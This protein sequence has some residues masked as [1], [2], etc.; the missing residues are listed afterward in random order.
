MLSV[1]LSFSQISKILKK[2]LTNMYMKFLSPNATFLIV[3]LVGV[4]FLSAVFPY[5]FANLEGFTSTGYTSYTDDKPMDSN[6]SMLLNP[7]TDTQCK[8]IY[9]FD[10]LFCSPAAPNTEIDPFHP[11]KSG[12]T[13]SGLGL[14]KAGG[15]VCLDENTLNLLHTRGGNSS[16]VGSTSGT[17]DS[18][19]G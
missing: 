3:F 4:L 6:I 5:Q 10:G 19:I 14:T 11:L 12:S 13:C 17:K 15:S 9:G 7:T 18:Q 1:F 8:K 16:G 2:Y